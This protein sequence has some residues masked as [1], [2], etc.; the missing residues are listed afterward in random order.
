MNKL[1]L[2]LLLICLATTGVYAQMLTWVGSGSESDPYEVISIGH[3]IEISSTQNLWNKHFIQTIDLNASAVTELSPIGNV[4][5]KFTGSYDG[6]NHTISNLYINRPSTNNVGLF[7]SISE[8]NISNLGIVNATITGGNNVGGLVGQVADSSSITNCYVA[9]AVS[10]KTIVGG[11]IGKVTNSS[12]TGSYA[13]ANVSSTG[14]YIGGLAGYSSKGSE[15]S[16]CYAT[17]NV[18][19]NDMVGGLVGEAL[20]NSAFNSCYATGTVSGTHKVGGLVGLLNGA[21]ITSSYATGDFS[22][23]GSSQIAGGLVGYAAS[24]TISKSYAT[25]NLTGDYYLGGLVGK[26]S[27]ATIIDCYATGA[28]ESAIA[29]IGGLIGHVVNSS[30]I[31]NCYSIGAVSASKQVGG[32]VGV[33]DSLDPVSS[34]PNSFWDKETSGQTASLLGTG[35]TTAQMQ[36]VNNYVD[37]DFTEIWFHD[38]NKNAGYPYL[39]NYIDTTLPVELT[40]FV[41]MITNTNFSKI[42]WSTASETNI[43]GFN[44]YRNEKKDINTATRINHSYIPATN[45]SHGSDYFYIDETV[46]MNSIY[47]Y[48][49]ESSE[50]NGYSE[51][52]GPVSVRIS[53]QTEHLETVLLVSQLT[54]NYPNP[55]NPETNIEFFVQDGETANLTIYNLKG[56]VVNSANGFGSG[57]QSYFWNGTDSSGKQV[58]SGVYFYKLKTQSHESI[59]KMIV[60]K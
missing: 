11:I 48:W 57:K 36:D 26:T 25:G 47:Y 7:G 1:F 54:G 6:Q 3:L 29:L 28:V 12:I 14:N 8:A 20:V 21:T 13:T 35:K 46:E 22:Q 10:G 53:Q 32:L 33:V 58:A 51:F 43:V 59:R 15:F 4:T 42:I 55:F 39:S 38:I 44:I 31:T 52:F 34:A 40:S 24:S 56:Q 9:G 23:I 37:W 50:F 60:E 18:I 27:G 2:I 16:N 49:L 17:G 19:G 30:T 5:T 41:A 45:S